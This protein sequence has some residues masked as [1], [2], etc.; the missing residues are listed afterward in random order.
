MNLIMVDPWML[1]GRMM[2]G[3]TLSWFWPMDAL[4]NGCGLDGRYHG[5]GPWMLWG[6]DEAWIELYGFPTDAPGQAVNDQVF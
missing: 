6:T 2:S 4:G 5:F 1:R 3:W